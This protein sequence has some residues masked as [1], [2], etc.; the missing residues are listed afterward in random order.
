MAFVGLFIGELLHVCPFTNKFYYLMFKAIVQIYLATAYNQV[1]YFP[2][3]N[4]KE[5][6]IYMVITT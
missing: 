4:M 3:K 6:L 1:V 5:Y 2:D